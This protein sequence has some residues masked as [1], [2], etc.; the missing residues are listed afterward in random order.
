MPSGRASS[1]SALVLWG[2]PCWLHALACCR[3]LTRPLARPLPSHACPN[4]SRSCR[5]AADSP[6]NSRPSVRP[7]LCQLTS[8]AMRNL[9][10]SRRVSLCPR[11]T[12]R[13]RDAGGRRQAASKC[14]PHCKR[15]ATK[16]HSKNQRPATS[17]QLHQLRARG[18]QNWIGISSAVL[19]AALCRQCDD[20]SSSCERGSVACSWTPFSSRQRRLPAKS[21][22]KI[23]PCGC[24][25]LSL[26]SSA[27]S[28]CVHD[29]NRV[30]HYC[31]NKKPEGCEV[32]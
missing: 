20:P 24:A 13:S 7:V 14:S 32:C 21:E 2:C 30:L 12:L 18:V 6:G 28:A 29:L 15:N 25:A 19:L 26:S 22:S 3:H 11:V 1:H 27:C 9:H 4:W 5:R 10:P 31:L 23:P 8:D 16:I 17:R